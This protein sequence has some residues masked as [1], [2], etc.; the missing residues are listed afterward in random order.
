[1][2]AWCTSRATAANTGPTSRRTSRHSEW[3]TISLIRAVAVRRRTA[4]VVADAHRLDDSRPYLWK[5]TDYGRTWKSLAGGLPRDIYLH[6]VREDRSGAVSLPGD[7]T[8]RVVLG[9]RWGHLAGARLNLP[10]VAVH[11]LVVKNNDLVLGTHG[12]SIW[13]LDDLTPIRQWSKEVAGEPAHIFRRS[14]RFRWEYRGSF[15]G[16]GREN[17]PQGAVINYYL[18]KKPRGHQAGYPGRGGRW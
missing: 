1:M 6:A 15:H 16:D 14:R 4:Y 3:V 5:T 8:G 11:D 9:G 13:I 12:R 10:T 2:T 17:P 18:K 7:R